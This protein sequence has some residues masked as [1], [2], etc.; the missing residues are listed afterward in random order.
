MK[1]K[2]MRIKRELEEEMRK[3]NGIEGNKQRKRMSDGK[4]AKRRLKKTR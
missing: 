1:G 3:G 2:G 4:M